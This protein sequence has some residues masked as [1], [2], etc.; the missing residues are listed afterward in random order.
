LQPVWA[1]G[2]PKNLEPD[3]LE[4]ALLKAYSPCATLAH[5]AK[6]KRGVFTVRPHGVKG[7]LARQRSV[8]SHQKPT[9]F[10]LYSPIRPSELIRF[11]VGSDEAAQRVHI[12]GAQRVHKQGRRP[13]TCRWG[14]AKAEAA[15]V[16]AGC[17]APRRTCTQCTRAH[18][19]MRR[20][21]TQAR[22]GGSYG[23]Y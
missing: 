10:V 4:G 9:R 15:A 23:A 2:K 13:C 19:T 5:R 3:C 12:Q 20:P 16:V 22:D 18:H 8:P 21:L 17:R 1:M 14:R 7:C 11:T 6:W